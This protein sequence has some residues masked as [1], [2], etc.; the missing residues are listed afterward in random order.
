MPSLDQSFL[1]RNIADGM[2]GA[3]L[4]S[5]ERGGLTQGEKLVGVGVLSCLIRGFQC[6]GNARKGI[7]CDITGY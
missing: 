7:V 1:P 6:Q 4:M 2:L 3:S 5:V